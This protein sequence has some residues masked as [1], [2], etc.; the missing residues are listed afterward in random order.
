[1][2][3]QFGRE[4]LDGELCVNGEKERECQELTQHEAWT[5][6]EG[7]GQQGKSERVDVG[8]RLYGSC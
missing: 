2:I 4:V 3:P 6:R 5:G 7:G 1:L 8:P